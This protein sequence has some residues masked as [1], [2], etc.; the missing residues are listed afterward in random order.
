MCVQLQY[1][2]LGDSL[3]RR[4]HFGFDPQQVIFARTNSLV[5]A[6]NL[7]QDQARARAAL[8][9]IRAAAR[10]ASDFPTTQSRQT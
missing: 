1:G 5:T 4:S 9:L 6:R 7:E 10:G 8:L 2:T 3:S